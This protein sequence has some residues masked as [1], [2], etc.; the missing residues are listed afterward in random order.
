MQS[1][2]PHRNRLG[3]HDFHGIRVQLPQN[4]FQVHD[5]GFRVWAPSQKTR[6]GTLREL[7]AWFFFFPCQETIVQDSSDL[8]DSS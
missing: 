8:K 2:A 4:Q 5:V 1:N 3:Q 6:A 7:Y